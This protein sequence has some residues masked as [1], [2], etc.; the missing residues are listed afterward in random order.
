MGSNKILRIETER[1]IIRKFV[2]DD[3]KDL[4]EIAISKKQSQFADCDHT[5]PT[6]EAGIKGAVEYFS[7]GH[8]FLA[9]EVKDLHKVVCLI[10]FNFMDDERTL[11]IGHVINSE[12]LSNDYEY[13]A[14]KALYNYG[15]IQLGAERIQANWALNDKDKLAPLFKLG[16]K[17][18]ETGMANKFKPDMDGKIS[19]FEGCK[20]IITKEEWLTNPAR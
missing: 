18:T 6:D 5:W 10:N 12:Y 17:V 19:Q 2:P 3:W 13:E 8:Q 16:M 1:L 14:L 7:K 4:Q 20:L 15:F 9:V 11:D